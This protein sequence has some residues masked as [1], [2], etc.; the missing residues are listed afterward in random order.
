MDLIK[1]DDDKDIFINI[2]VDLKNEKVSEKIFNLTTDSNSFKASSSYLRRKEIIWSAINF[3][4]SE[5][6]GLTI[7]RKTVSFSH[8]DIYFFQKDINF[9]NKFIQVFGEINLNNNLLILIKN[10]STKLADLLNFSNNLKEITFTCKE[11]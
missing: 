5:N 1:N 3:I 10:N 4:K 8:K 7:N 9:E 6:A 2:K 11:W